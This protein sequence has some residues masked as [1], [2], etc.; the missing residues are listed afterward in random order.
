MFL[1][2]EKKNSLHVQKS[3]ILHEINLIK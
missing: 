3:L 1:L 2:F